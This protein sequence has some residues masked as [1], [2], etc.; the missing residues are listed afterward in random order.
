M[1]TTC[2]SFSKYTLWGVTLQQS[3]LQ[4]N[5][6]LLPSLYQPYLYISSFQ[7]ALEKDMLIVAVNWFLSILGVCVCVCVLQNPWL[8]ILWEISAVIITGVFH[9]DGSVMEMTTVEMIPTNKTAVRAFLSYPK[10]QYGLLCIK[11]FFTFTVLARIL[12]VTGKLMSWSG[13]AGCRGIC[14]FQTA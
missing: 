7:I 14:P 4:F 12:S 11:I 8:V 1:R 5:F 9:C 2:I 3:L 10:L 13:G 6:L